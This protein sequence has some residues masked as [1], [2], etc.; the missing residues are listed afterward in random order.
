MDTT[1]PIGYDRIGFV[2]PVYFGGLPNLMANFIRS[3]N[4]TA[5]SA[6]YYFAVATRGGFAGAPNAQVDTLLSQKGVHLDYGE[7]VWMNANFVAFYNMSN[8]VIRHSLKAYSKRVT[9]VISDIQAMVKNDN[10]QPNKSREEA[11]AKAIRSVHE[12]DLDYNV[13]DACVSCGICQKVCPAGNI[14]LADGRPTFSHQCEYCMACIQHC[15]Q[16]ALNYKDKTQ[17]RKRYTHP[18]IGFQILAKYYNR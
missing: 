9:P 14:T 12:K 10:S 15:P 6:K 3:A 18:D 2:Y 4:F 7:K 5:Q 8:F 13:S 1:I 11:Y 17:K 16:K